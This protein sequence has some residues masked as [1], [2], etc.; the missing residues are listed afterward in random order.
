M[1]RPGRTSVTRIVC[2]RPGRAMSLIA[3]GAPANTVRLTTPLR[4]TGFTL[5]SRTYEA[6]AGNGK[7]GSPTI[8]RNCIASPLPAFPRALSAPFGAVAPPPPVFP[9]RLRMPFEATV[10]AIAIPDPIP[11]N[12]RNFLRSI[13]SMFIPSVRRAQVREPAQVVRVGPDLVCRQSSIRH[14]G[15]LDVDHVVRELPSIQ[16]A[17]GAREVVRQ[18]VR[19]EDLRDARC[20]RDGV[21]TERHER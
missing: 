12:F 18:D 4:V 13:G 19:E 9:R 11:T 20:L 17:R 3:P 7:A 21:A 1:S 10:P 2:E 16:E 8:A 14:E 15:Q 5:P 6:Y